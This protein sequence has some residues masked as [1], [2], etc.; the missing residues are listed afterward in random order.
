MPLIDLR[1]DTVTRPTPAMRRAMADAEVG[2]DVFGDDP[3]VIRLEAMAAERMGKEA[4]LF[5]ASG[6]MGNLV[7]LLA[8][9][10]RGDEVIVG[11]Q[12]HT[13]INEQGGMAALGGIQPRAVRNQPDGS[14]DLDEVEAA[15]RGDNLHYPRTRL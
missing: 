4:G 13:L 2:D 5:V 3:T 11:D 7:S 10:G 9:C 15:I 14:L 6:T 8:Q 1:S 12:A